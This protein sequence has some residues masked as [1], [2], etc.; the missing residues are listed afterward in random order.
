MFLDRLFKTCSEEERA[1]TN[2][3]FHAGGLSVTLV[4]ILVSFVWSW[5]HTMPSTV[6]IDLGFWQLVI[7]LLVAA[8]LWGMCIEGIDLLG[9]RGMVTLPRTFARRRGALFLCGAAVAVVT[10][11]LA[12]A[13]FLL[14]VPDEF[15][16]PSSVF[17]RGAGLY[18]PVFVLLFFGGIAVRIPRPHHPFMAS[19][20][21]IAPTSRH[22]VQR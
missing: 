1:L 13:T 3:W 6:P 15:D 20:R 10:Y 17:R 19:P 21:F 2:N 9:A 14:L 5:L 4:V 7:L 22:R 12:A 18:V 11:A 16:S 8:V